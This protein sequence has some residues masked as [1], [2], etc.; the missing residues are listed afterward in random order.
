VLLIAPMQY[1][2]AYFATAVSY[3]SKMFMKLAPALPV[4]L[5]TLTSFPACL[6]LHLGQRESKKHF[7]FY[8]SSTNEEL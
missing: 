1:S 4:L 8:E 2:Q 7:K 5:P 6:D 3:K